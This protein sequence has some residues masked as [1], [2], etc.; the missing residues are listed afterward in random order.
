MEKLVEVKL[1]ANV[2]DSDRMLFEPYTH[3]YIKKLKTLTLTDIFITY[4]GLCLNE[5]GLIPESIHSSADTYQDMVKESAYYV[6]QSLNDRN[7]LL[8]L[9]D[10][11]KYLVIHHPWSSNYWHWMSEAI[12][13][14]W[15]VRKDSK[16]MILILPEHLQKLRFVKDS[17]I[18]FRFKGILYLPHGKSVQ[19]RNLCLPQIKPINDSYYPNELKSIRKCYLRSL[20]RRRVQDNET[21]KIYIS[22]KKASKR[23]V[24]NED[25]IEELLK[26]YGFIL[27]C[28]EDFS[29]LELVEMYSS[30][31]HLVSIHGAGMMNMLF[32]KENSTVLEL[33][34]KK[35]NPYD[36]HSFAFWYLADALGFKYYQQT[37][38]PTE[39]Q[40]DFFTADFYVDKVLLERNI[41]KMLRA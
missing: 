10:D 30:A 15:M 21:Q 26:R 13:R 29:F 6:K 39:E 1:P 18:P 25:E 8:E 41:N 37:C 19:V 3:Y 9:F 11:E 36:W 33:H 20:A 27:T 12:F 16:N 14:A 22:R 38:E 23:K 31:T 4:S 7:N 28:N 17:L 24:I 34:K 2:S 5:N 32:M 35:T 40:S